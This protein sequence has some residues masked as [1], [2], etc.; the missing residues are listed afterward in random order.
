MPPHLR[1]SGRA[2][3][4]VP[5]RSVLTLALLLAS[6]GLLRAAEVEFVRVW[7]EWREAASFERISEYF[8]GKEN[9]GSQVLLRTQPESRAGF[10]FLARVNNTGPATPGAKLVLSLIK[11]DSPKTR[12]Y[13][14]PIALPAG[15][16]VYNLGLTGADWVGP[17]VHPVAW[18]IEVVTTDGRLLGVQKSFLWERPAK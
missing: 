14:F 10:Y 2:L 11:P 8:D 12:V 15:Q 9:S 4:F 13:T 18:K 6:A 1:P 17:K 5:M 7:P 3:N 16:T